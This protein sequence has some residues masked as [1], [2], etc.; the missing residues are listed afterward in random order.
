MKKA[1]SLV[2]GGEIVLLVANHLL[3]KLKLAAGRKA[4]FIVV[5]K[6]IEGQT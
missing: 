5:I 4:L 3:I 2:Q 1:C 6:L